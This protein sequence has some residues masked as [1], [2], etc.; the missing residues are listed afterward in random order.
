M[1]TGTITITASIG[2][3]SLHKTIQESGDH[4]NVYGDASTDIPLAGGKEVTDWVESDGTAEC[5]LPSG[6]GYSNGK[7]DVF[8]EGGS[9]YD[10][11]GIIT[12]DVVLDLD[13]GTGDEFPI[14]ETT[15]VIVCPPQQINTAIDGD[16]IQML[17]INCTKRASL[18]FEDAEEEPVARIHVNG[19]QPYLY[20]KQS[21]ADSPLA[22][23][24]VTV[25]WA[26]CGETAAS[27]LTIL[28]LEDSTP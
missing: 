27:V 12:E 3:V 25:C 26:S 24:P 17:V 18:Y 28:S 4:P 23:E 19:D 8:W 7:F 9:R 15:G 22:G 16:E 1:G 6:H 20:Y 11:D 10:V 5:N 14:S 21:G 13:G 2:G